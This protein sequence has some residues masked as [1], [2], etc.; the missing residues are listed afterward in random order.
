MKTWDW[1]LWAIL[2]V[3]LGLAIVQLAAWLVVDDTV[4]LWFPVV[5]L[6]FA[7]M[8]GYDLRKRKRTRTA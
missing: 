5:N 1:I 7:A 2:L 3:S 8:A 6:L 4:S